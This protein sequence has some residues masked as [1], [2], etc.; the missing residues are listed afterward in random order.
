M[1]ILTWC[2]LMGECHQVNENMSHLNNKNGHNV[3]S[4]DSTSSNS[5]FL[6]K[7]CQKVQHCY[8]GYYIW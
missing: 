6:L 7:N 3:F 5:I 4:I 1:C 8:V 2:N